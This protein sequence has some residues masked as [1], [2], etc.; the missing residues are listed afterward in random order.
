[1]SKRTW[2]H[3]VVVAGLLFLSIT[4]VND[5]LGQF[6]YYLPK[7][8]LLSAEG[9]NRIDVYRQPMKPMNFWNM[10]G[11]QKTPQALDGVRW[12]EASYFVNNY[13]QTKKLIVFSKP[14]E[15]AK[16]VLLEYDSLQ[17]VTKISSTLFD[18]TG[19]SQW[20]EQFMYG[21][22]SI[23]YLK[24]DS[25]RWLRK[26]TV[27]SDTFLLLDHIRNEEDSG[28]YSYDPADE[29]VLSQA[30]K[31]GELAY[32]KTLRYIMQEG[33]PDSIYMKMDYFQEAFDTYQTSG[34]PKHVEGTADVLENGEAVVPSSNPLSFILDTGFKFGDHRTKARL[35]MFIEEQRFTSDSLIQ[36]SEVWPEI[37]PDGTAYRWY[38]MLEYHR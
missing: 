23:V 31:N 24:E 8:E 29:T 28:L 9:I 14:Q 17:R 15:K 22:D 1:M 3:H 7:A 25:K 4:S 37:Q 19:Q 32:S 6:T 2:V 10:T 5:V 34:T 26:M 13:G 18:R 20:T 35:P 12:L 30:F 38:Y 33:R 36:E 21:P 27:N 16:E 11:V